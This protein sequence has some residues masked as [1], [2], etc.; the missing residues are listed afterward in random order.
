M[1]L[2]FRAGLT[3]PLSQDSLTLG[4]TE[5]TSALAVASPVIVTR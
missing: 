3:G 5:A 4:K 1:L 2:V